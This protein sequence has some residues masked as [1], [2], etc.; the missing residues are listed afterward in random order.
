MNVFFRL[1]LLG[2]GGAVKTHMRGLM[3]RGSFNLTQSL[4]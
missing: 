2:Y 4:A 1:I 3:D